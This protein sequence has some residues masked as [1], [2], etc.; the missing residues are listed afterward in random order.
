MQ[1][2]H[3]R[4]AGNHLVSGVTSYIA[5]HIHM[6]FN[7]ILL[8]PALEV[9]ILFGWASPSLPCNSTGT[10][11]LNKITPSSWMTKGQ[12]RTR[13]IISTI[14]KL[15]DAVF[16][17]GDVLGTRFIPGSSRKAQENSVWI[18]RTGCK[19]RPAWV[20][21]FCMINFHNIWVW[22]I[23]SFQYQCFLLEFENMT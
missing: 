21:L 4:Q 23:R 13:K 5:L 12:V 16:M 14:L 18:G 11:S 7:Q 8:Q 1:V 19:W 2:R 10:S 3:K 17:E 9:A 20:C 15:T 6:Q 22:A